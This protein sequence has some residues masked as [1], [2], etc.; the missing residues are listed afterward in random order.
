MTSSSPALA[1]ANGARRNRYR[2]TGPDA[3]N[4]TRVL[5]PNIGSFMLPGHLASPR[6]LS[7]SPPPVEFPEQR[8]F[9]ATIFLERGVSSS[10]MTARNFFLQLLLLVLVRLVLA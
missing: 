2:W 4:P 3:D 10:K 7:L 9:V 5:S 1:L 6:M 8:S